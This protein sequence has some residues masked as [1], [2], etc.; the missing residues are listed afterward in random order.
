[1]ECVIMNTR[2]EFI[3]SA[4]A[5]AASAMAGCVSREHSPRPQADFLA[6]ELIQLGCNIQKAPGEGRGGVVP[7]NITDPELAESVERF[8]L[9]SDRI[10]FDESVWRDVSDHFRSRGVNAIVIDLGDSVVYPRHPEIAIRGAWS[11]EKLRKELSRLRS[12]GF[13]PIPKLNFSTTHNPWMGEWRKMVS[14][15]AYYGFCSD[16]IRDVV[17]IFDNPRYFHI[18]CDEERL[19]PQDS[20]IKYVVVRQGDLWYHDLNQLVRE[21]ESH[22]ARAWMWS[23]ACWSNPDEYIRKV[24]RTV[25]QSNWY[26]REFG[27]ADLAKYTPERRKFLAVARETYHVLDKAGYDQIPCSSNFYDGNRTM[28]DTAVY[29]R[30][31][32]TASRVK[33]LMMASWVTMEPVAKK[34]ICEGADRLCDAMKI[35]RG[36]GANS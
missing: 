5:A 2:R 15:R 23:D 26:Y 16:M 9:Y 33:G 35:W 21:V 36:K 1:M 32:L 7:E 28:E 22:G 8:Y 10:K 6:A 13:E 27:E 11:V 18:G 20:K 12:M 25:L 34:R 24:P 31:K 30:E 4:A 19:P 14:S 29:A 17:E 3:N